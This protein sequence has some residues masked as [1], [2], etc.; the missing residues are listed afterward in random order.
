MGSGSQINGALKLIGRRNYC[1]EC[2]MARRRRR[3]VWIRVSTW[4]SQTQT[5]L[6]VL[7]YPEKP[8]QPLGSLLPDPLLLRPSPLRLRR[9]SHSAGPQW[10]SSANSEMSSRIWGWAGLRAVEPASLRAAAPRWD[11]SP[12]TA[13]LCVLEGN[14]SWM[15]IFV[16]YVI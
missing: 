6:C 2:V 7:I 11:Y 8:L 3:P 12:I 16:E 15:L 5:A 4:Q 9:K 14:Q 10:P 1:D 13:G